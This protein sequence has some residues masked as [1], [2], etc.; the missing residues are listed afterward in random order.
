MRIKLSV[1]IFIG[2]L[3]LVG[4][5]FFGSGP[6][7]TA[8]DFFEAAEAGDSDAVY[9]MMSTN[10][11]RRFSKDKIDMG[12]ES[13]ARQIQNKGG[14]QSIEITRE[15]IVENTA[16]VVVDIT[17]GNGQVETE[18]VPMVK[19]NGEWHIDVEK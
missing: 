16:V 10:A 17:Y 8:Q 2:L 12:I 7:Q 13:R 9:S 1:L 3:S 18:T 11:I 5:G 6:S 4:C 15:D 19:E 14:I